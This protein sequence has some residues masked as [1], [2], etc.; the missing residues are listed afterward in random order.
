LEIDNSSHTVKPIEVVGCGDIGRRLARLFLQQE[1]SPRA[2]IKSDAS[3]LVCRRLGLSYRKLDLDGVIDITT[4]QAGARILYTIPPRPQGRTDTRIAVFLNALSEHRIDTLVLISTTGVY[5][6]CAGRWVNEESPIRPVVER[7]QRR[8][9]AETQARTWATDRGCKI[10]ILRVPGIYALDRLPLKRIR[11]GAAMLRKDQSPWSNRIHADDLARACY[12]ALNSGLSNE[13][14]NIADDAPGT[15][16]EYFSA[17]ADY[18][19]L[20]RPPEISLEEAQQS[21][22]P[23][24]LSYLAESR[25]IDNRKMK[26]LLGLVLQYP[27]L[28]QGLENR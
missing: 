24:M 25:R 17:V 15:M 23:G 13:I 4:I 28:E 11:G 5:G 27:G 22:S 6:D 18:A 20:P 16:N 9:D 10:I 7:A 1:I 8:A 21:L 26:S 3:A 14:I 19:G 2:W 12:L